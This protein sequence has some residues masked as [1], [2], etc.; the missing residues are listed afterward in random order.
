METN[1][2]Q[3]TSDAIAE[4]VAAARTHVQEQPVVN[5]DETGWTEAKMK[6]WLWAAVTTAVTAFVVRL[7]R[8]RAAFDDLVGPAPPVLTTDR[9]GVYTHLP[10]DRRQVCGAHLR[11][12]FQAMI[13]RA[14]AGSAV[15][16]DLLLHADILLRQ[17]KRV[18]DG[19]L[20][21]AGFRSRHAPWVRAEVR[22][23]LDRGAASACAK[24][25]GTCREVLAV[26][27][28]LGTFAAVPGV[29][30]TNNAAERALRHAVC[31]RK[32]SYGTDSPAGSRFR[33]PCGRRW[34]ASKP[35]PCR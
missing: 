17:W 29:E 31:W 32:T 35:P 1:L 12:D 11:R 3:D 27:A 25:A 15:G 23:L 5:A 6:A 16:V 22:S 10:A 33:M 7:T 30:P 34:C 26:E 13:D 28:S 4:P 14:N 9:Y 2:E 21:R 18:R 19:T 24:T 20:T 8:G